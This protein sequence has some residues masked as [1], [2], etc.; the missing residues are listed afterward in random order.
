MEWQLKV[1]ISHINTDFDGFASM[2]AASILHPGAKLVFPGSQ[3]RMLREFLKKEG[4]HFKVAKA[5]DIDI[6]RISALVLVD[7]RKI[8]KIGPFRE[9][10][11]KKGVKIHI[12]D[13]HPSSASA[14][15]AHKEIIKKRGATTTIMTEILRRKKAVISKKQATVMIMGI[16][17]ETGCLTYSSTTAED[18]KAVIWLLEKGADLKRVRE[19]FRREMSEGQLSILSQLL[20]SSSVIRR[21]KLKFAI[22]TATENSYVDDAAVSV[23]RAMDIK[24]YD[25]ITSLIRMDERIHL[26]VRSSTELF[27]CSKLASLFGGGGHGFAASAVIKDIAVAE[28]TDV[29]RKFFENLIPSKS[30]A[31]ELMAPLPLTIEAKAKMKDALLSINRLHFNVAPVVSKG[32]RVIGIVNRKTLEKAVNH[33]MGGDTVGKYVNY[34]Y[35][36]VS[37]DSP[38]Q[39]VINVMIRENIPFVTVTKKDELQGVITRSD[40]IKYMSENRFHSDFE[41][42]G[43]MKFTLGRE[44]YFRERNIRRIVEERM[45]KDFL[46]SFETIRKIADRKNVNAYLVG[47]I[48]RD[49]L[50]GENNFDVDIVLEREG[51]AFAKEFAKKTSGKVKSHGRFGTSSV[52]L[53][54]GHR[55][56]FATARTEFYESPAEL[57]V[58]FPGSLKRDL[59]RRDF[60]INALA[61]RINGK[62]PFVLVD[63]FGGQRDLKDKVIRILHSLSFVE[64]PTRAFRALRFEARLGFKIGKQTLALLKD[65]ISKGVFGKVSGK[66]ILAELILIL[67]EKK[68]QQIL[69][70]M[71]ELGLLEAISPHLSFDSRNE[72]IFKKV[73]KVLDW[74]EIAFPEKRITHWQIYFMC[75]CARLD[76]IKLKTVGDRLSIPASLRKKLRVVIETE[77]VIRALEK[78]AKP[79]SVYAV[80]KG[81]NTEVILFVMAVAK[82]ETV[83]K[84]ITGFLTSYN[85]IKNTINGDDLKKMG[86]S[87]GPLY[88]KILSE[89]HSYR[90]DGLISDKKGEIRLAE[91]IYREYKGN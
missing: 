78:A 35:A 32:G 31:Y 60:S 81:L 26:I 19:Y 74:C 62:P 82:R 59:Y 87:E 72:D 65:S 54:S 39:D 36:S 48:V 79:S 91:K 25:A 3:E 11:R 51:I 73:E 8:G 61:V 38:A 22:S 41:D 55:I 56:D 69:K 44:D 29:I 85:K 28:A 90:L 77:S 40:L 43:E 45:T 34:N 15:K 63:Y 89:I 13:H 1:I 49:I 75:L 20:S 27:D 70:R 58:V 2:V 18:L 9:I 47:G 88:S 14:I 57:P 37:Y 5:G 71:W 66:R 76:K 86:I 80:L 4:R 24:G 68:N 83:R 67:N 12:Y 52:F 21:K 64:D 16:Y 6:S 17:E 84:R 30:R 42:A 33:G 50:I 7:V 46:Q 53:P 10:V 23:S